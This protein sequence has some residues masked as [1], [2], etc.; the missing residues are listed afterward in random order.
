[1]APAVPPLL[2]RLTSTA[3][4]ILFPPRCVGCGAF[5]RLLCPACFEGMPR[6]EPPR[7]PIC[8]VP[9]HRPDAL[10]WRCHDRTFHFKAARCPFVYEGA[11][12]EAVHALKYRGVSALAPLMAQAMAACLQQWA[13]PADLLV[14]VPLA[15]RRRRLRGFNQSE[16]LAREMARIV[17]LPVDSRALIR[18]RAAPPQASSADEAARRANVAN[19]FQADAARFRGRRPL[20]IDDVIT[21]G[22]TLD[23]CARSLCDAG[24]SDVWALT[25]A[26]ED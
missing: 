13:P 9:S 15:G 10:C 2:S 16:L 25:F 3:L 8:W 24:T 5:G 26:R 18:R 17:G 21:S 22:A 14:P 20:L 12:R 4:D 23:A 19:A 6:A 7:C 11:A 1:M